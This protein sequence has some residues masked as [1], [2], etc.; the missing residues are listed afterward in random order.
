MALAIHPMHGRR[1]G[2]C[3]LQTHLEYPE[4]SA[5]GDEVV[6]RSRQGIDFGDKED[7]QG[8]AESG[9][10]AVAD[11]ALFEG[12]VCG[13]CRSRLCSRCRRLAMACRWRKSGQRGDA[14]GQMS[15]SSAREGG[16]PVLSLFH[17]FYFILV[18]KY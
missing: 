15:S 4:R 12:G 9:E 17:L 14:Q 5:S 8:R 10:T 16:S 1:C 13:L 6:E 7:R 2:E 11:G 3:A 18:F